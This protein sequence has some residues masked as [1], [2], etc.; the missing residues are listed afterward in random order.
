[1][2]KEFPGLNHFKLRC[3]LSLYGL[4]QLQAYLLGSLQPH[5]S[6]QMRSK[7]DCMA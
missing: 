6:K 2:W 5:A 1:M 3:H 7:D 4:L